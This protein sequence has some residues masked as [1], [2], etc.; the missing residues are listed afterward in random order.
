MNGIPAMLSS[1]APLYLPEDLKVQPDIRCQTAGIFDLVQDGSSRF[2]GGDRPQ[3]S[4]P[5][6]ESADGIAG[7]RL[8]QGMGKEG[9]RLSA[10]EAL[11]VRAL[12]NS[13]FAGNGSEWVIYRIHQ[14]PRIGSITNYQMITGDFSPQITQITIIG[15]GFTTLPMPVT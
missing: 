1:Q 8:H 12:R 15:I 11:T 9:G 7:G 5:I 14:N 6:H 13:K 2:W 10:G 3:K 4:G